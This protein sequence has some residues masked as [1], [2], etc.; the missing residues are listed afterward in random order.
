MAYAAADVPLPVAPRPQRAMERM[1]SAGVP[2]P[3]FNPRRQAERAGQV[4]KLAEPTFETTGA[5][6]PVVAV[7][8]DAEPAPLL[9]MTALDTVGLRQWIGAASTRQMAYALL[10][11]PDYTQT[12][13]LM[14]KPAVTY[15]A[16][17]GEVAY[18]GLRTDRFTGPSVLQP[19]MIDLSRQVLAS[20]R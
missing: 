2:M 8:I 14:R 18:A 17:F 9:T 15:R 16:G 13:D 3:L 19:R 11:M 6:A 20:I 1:T 7:A 10:T 12:L 5:I 4:A